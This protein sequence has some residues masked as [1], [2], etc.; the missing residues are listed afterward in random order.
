[1]NSILKEYRY[2]N[3]ELQKVQAVRLDSWE[4][5][6]FV[7]PP[8]TREALEHIASIYRDFFMAV[9][10]A[11]FGMMYV[12]HI[13]EDMELPFEMGEMGDR[14]AAAKRFLK[15]KGRTREGKAFLDRLEKAGWLYV[16]KGKNPFYRMYMPYDGCG[17]LSG[18]GARVKVNA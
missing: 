2:P 11:V 14:H 10:P 8:I 17:F 7:R 12:F 5:L 1:M 18:T 6:D 13:P 3:G 4:Q 16:V 15:K 9:A